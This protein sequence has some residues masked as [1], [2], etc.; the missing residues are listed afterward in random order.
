MFKAKNLSKLNFFFLLY[1][2]VT[3]KTSD[4]PYFFLQVGFA[5]G[6]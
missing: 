6:L 1:I 5:K 3:G 4:P 2:D